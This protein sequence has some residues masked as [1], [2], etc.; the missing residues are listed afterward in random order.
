MSLER[1]ALYN[2]SRLADLLM[3]AFQDE[4][5]ED[6]DTHRFHD[7]NLDVLLVSLIEDIMELVVTV[8][9]EQSRELLELLEETKQRLM[10]FVGKTVLEYNRRVAVVIIFRVI[11]ALLS[12]LSTVGTEVVRSSQLRNI[13]RIIMQL[14]FFISKSSYHQEAKLK[15]MKNS[16]NLKLNFI[17]LLLNYY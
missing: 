14:L 3:N 11:P 7:E 10:M 6:I 5:D 9:E 4:K 2:I 13:L 17:R 15:E 16:E 12:L 8:T 1:I